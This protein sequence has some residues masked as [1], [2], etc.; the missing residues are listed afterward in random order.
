VYAVET[1]AIVVLDVFAKE[2]NKTPREVLSNCKRR[3][4]AFRAT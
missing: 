3:L 4:R 1:E 2:T